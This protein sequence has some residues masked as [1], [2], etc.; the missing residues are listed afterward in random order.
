MNFLILAATMAQTATSVTV[1]VEGLPSNCKP[2]IKLQSPS[3][4]QEIDPATPAKFTTAGAYSVRG[5]SFRF[6]GEIVDTIYDAAEVKTTVNQGQATT[7]TLRY[8]PRGGTGMLWTVAERIDEDTDDFTKGEVRAL[9]AAALKQGG[10]SDATRKFTIPSRAYGGMIA[11]DGSLIFAG[12]WDDNAILRI[13]TDQ[14]G[15]AGQRTKLA[16]PEPAFV[17]VDPKGRFW[18]HLAQSAKCYAQLN[19]GGA[20]I[21]ELV[22]S[23]DG[24][25]I[26]FDNLVFAADGSMIVFSRGHIQRIPA[27][28]LTG[29]KTI[30]RGGVTNNTGTISQGALDQDGNLWITDE[31]SVVHK[32]AK[33]ADGSFSS[34]STEYAVPQ[35]TVGLAIDE[36][37][38]VWVLN[39]YSGE[40]LRL[41]KGER[42]FKV[43]GKFGKGHSPSSRLMFNPPPS[44]SPLAAAP[45]FVKTRLP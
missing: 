13:M 36:A 10:F 26:G 7:I 22:A 9:T 41:N 2:E 8:R 42:E 38:D 12:G 14:L 17:T 19:F 35:A 23:E 27:S 1:T 40:L 11:P 34:D 43:V 39:R 21:A 16:G 3:G 30:A 6:K 24:D 18:V 4:A 29:K 45:G 31:N 37:G 28:E 44:W 5:E 32:F 15:G 20:P 33:Q 25:Q